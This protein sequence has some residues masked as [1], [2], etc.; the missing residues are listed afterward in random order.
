MPS[1][2][3]LMLRKGRIC[4]LA[5]SNKLSSTFNS[6]ALTSKASNATR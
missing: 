4:E 3:M 5:A 1:A 2:V 6:C